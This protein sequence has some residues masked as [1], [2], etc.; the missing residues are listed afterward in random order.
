MIGKKK[1]KQKTVTAPIEKK[2]LTVTVVKHRNLWP[3]EVVESASLEI[4]K[5]QMDES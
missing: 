1:K 3:R 5:T 2:I 4:F